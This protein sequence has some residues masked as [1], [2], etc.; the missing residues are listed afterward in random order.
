MQ[1]RLHRQLVKEKEDLTQS[2]E[3]LKKLA[4]TQKEEIAALKIE[5]DKARVL[6]DIEEKSTSGVDEDDA[7]SKSQDGGL[8]VEGMKKSGI[9]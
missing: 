8:K 7:D 4:Q 5:L 1:N 2:V 3:D 9:K 6:V